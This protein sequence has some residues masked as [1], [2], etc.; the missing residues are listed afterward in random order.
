M[1]R[2]VSVVLFFLTAIYGAWGQAKY[3][4]K[5]I[6][7]AVRKL[8]I[9]SVDSIPV[10]VYTMDKDKHLV[11]VRKNKNNVIEHIGIKLF[12]EDMR[13]ANPLPVYDFIEYA[14]LNKEYAITDD[15]LAYSDV[16][17][18]KGS[19][20]DMRFISD[21]TECT[22]K[23]VDSKS[24]SVEWNVKDKG[25]VSMVFPIKYSLI[26][27]ESRRQIEQDFIDNV[28]KYSPQYNVDVVLSDSSN[29]KKMTEKGDMVVYEL[30]GEVYLDPLVNSNTY[31]CKHDSVFMPLFEEAFPELTVKNVILF[32][33]NDILRDFF[34]EARFVRMENDVDVRTLTLRQLVDFA[35]AEGCKPYVGISAVKDNVVK[36]T[37]FFYNSALGYDHIVSFTADVSKIETHEMELKAR[38]YL[39]SPTTNVKELFLDENLKKK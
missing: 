2:I 32:N 18:V 36:G 31:Y 15:N 34:V 30:A 9:E 22:V 21:S 4:S 33:S 6:E 13:N 38:V 37:L 26:L 28:C 27:G 25:T 11:V 17:F 5:H 1:R 35:V 20:K 12:P 3:A 23:N 7:Q 16:R 14:Y 29:L 24:Y 39:F 8:R 19:W 10:G